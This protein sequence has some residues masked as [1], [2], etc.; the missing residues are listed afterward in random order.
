[1]QFVHLLHMP[2]TV[3]FG[4]FW[5]FLAI[6]KDPTCTS[7]SFLKRNRNYLEDLLRNVTMERSKIREGMIWCMEH[8]ESSDEV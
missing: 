1:M 4:I 7:Y 8:A 5:V 6:L 2:I 3:F